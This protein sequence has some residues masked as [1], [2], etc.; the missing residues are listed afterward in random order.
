MSSVACS[1]G[2]VLGRFI[3]LCGKA[4]AYDS[5]LA[6]KARRAYISAM[7][8]FMNIGDRARLRERFYGESLSVLARL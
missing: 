8:N 5:A 2:R 1:D 6:C 3:G 7:I 4:V